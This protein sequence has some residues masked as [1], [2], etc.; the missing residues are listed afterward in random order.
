MTVFELPSPEHCWLLPADTLW[1]VLLSLLE[2]ALPAIPRA[3]MR[4]IG[5]ATAALKT[6]LRKKSVGASFLNGV[7]K[8]GWI[9][10]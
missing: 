4:G 9:G 2:L 7:C 3:F 6:T 5:A 8:Y 10:R 1:L